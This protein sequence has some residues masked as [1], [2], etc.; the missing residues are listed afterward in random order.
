MI[1]VMCALMKVNKSLLYLNVDTKYVYIVSKNYNKTKILKIAQYVN[2]QTG[3]N[4][5]SLEIDFNF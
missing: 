5:L 3:M 4:K 2:K 1:C